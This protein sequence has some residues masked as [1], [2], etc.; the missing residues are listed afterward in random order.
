M[1]RREQIG[2]GDGDKEKER[3]KG[4]IKQTKTEEVRGDLSEEERKRIKEKEEGRN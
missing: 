1:M 2:R 4:T 3:G